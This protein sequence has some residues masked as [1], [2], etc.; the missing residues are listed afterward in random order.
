MWGILFLIF[1]ALRSIIDEMVLIC[2]FGF[3]GNVIG[4]I[5]YKYGD[6]IKNKEGV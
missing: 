3:I 5:L 4:E 1:F 2:F 6:K